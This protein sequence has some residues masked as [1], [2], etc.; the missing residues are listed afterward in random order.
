MSQIDLDSL[1]FRDAPKIVGNVPGQKSAEI[2]ERQRRF[3][4]KAVSYSVG[5]P[6]VFAKAKGATLLDVDGNI[7]ID[8]FGGAAVLGAGHSNPVVMKAIR[9]Q[10]EQMV[11]SLDLATEVREKLSEKLV[12]LAPGKLRNNAKVL[13]GGPTGSDAVEAAIK[14]A[15]YNTKAHTLIAFEGGYHGMTGNALSVTADTAFRKD[16]MPMGQQVHFLPYSYCYRCPFGLKHPGCGTVCA[17]YS[18]HVLDDPSSGICDVAGIIVEPVQGEGGSIVPKKEFITKIDEIAKKNSI[19]LISDEI[20]SGMGRTGKMF[21]SDLMGIS[22]DIVTVSKALGGGTGY[23]LSAILY[24]KDYDTWGPGAHIGTF[25][26]FLPAMAG[27]IAYLDFLKDNN[28]LEHVTELGK[29]MLKRLMEFEESFDIVGEARGVGFMLGFELI[30]D[31]SSKTPSSEFAKKLRSEA[32][33]RGVIIEVGGHFHNVARI[34][35]P[36][37]LTRELADRGLDALEDALTEIKKNE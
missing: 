31:K 25:R 24:R 34:L 1:H 29:H 9:D 10:E 16:Y 14:L 7:Y 6:V 18:E 21:A 37:V 22:P 26:G 30:K 35:P 28:I 11:H 20:Q 5:I 15:K 23:P 12:Q 8:F 3:E 27:G 32:V 19:P 2:L 17:T 33:R 36:L 4:G 13:F